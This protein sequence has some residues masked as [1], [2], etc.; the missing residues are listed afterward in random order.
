MLLTF[1]LLAP[2]KGIENVIQALP[3]V[4]ERHPDVVYLVLGATHLQLRAREG[5]SYRLAM[6]RLAR[7]LGVERQVIFH[8]RFVTIEELIEYI[9]SVDLYIT[10]YLKPMQIVSGTLAYTVGAGKA[11][12]STPYWYAREMLAEGRGILVLFR[13]PAAIA[14]Q[15]NHLLEHET[16]RHA[17]RKNAYQ[18]GR[19][20]IW[21]LVARRYL[22]SF[23]RAKIEHTAKPAHLVRVALTERKPPGLPSPRLNHLMRMTDG[24]GIFQYAIYTVPNY[25]E[26]Y[27]TDDNAR[28]LMLAVLLD[29]LLEEVEFDGDSLVS[30]YLAFLF[31]AHNPETRRFRNFMGFDRRWLEEVGSEDSHGRA[32]VGLGMMIGRSQNDGY[33]SLACQLFES[34]VGMV[35]DFSSPRAWAF[36]LIAI[37][38][39]LRAFSGDRG[40]CQT[41]AVLADRLLGMY[42]VNSAPDWRWFEDTLTYANALLPHA[43]ILSGQW[44]GRG[45]MAAT[46]LEALDWMTGIQT[47]ERRYFA[48][49]GSN[50]FYP[51]GGALARFDQ[52][53]IDAHATIAACL[54]AW[55]MTRDTAWKDRARQAFD[56][57]IGLNDLGVAVYDPATGGC[58]DGLHPDRVNRNQGAESTLAFL[59]SLAEMRLAE[60]IIGRNDEVPD[61]VEPGQPASKAI[62][63]ARTRRG[64]RA[65]TRAR[66]PGRRLAGGW[67]DCLYSRARRNTSSTLAQAAPGSSQASSVPIWPFHAHT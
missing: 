18:F 25:A 30:R 36:T 63:A 34:A 57:F 16:E 49:I 59:L 3:A 46:G 64:L 19:Q 39:Y 13:N 4:L 65:G 53:P 33:R 37:H 48:P 43:L 27:T 21:P 20:M 17:K 28:A 62:G 8:N 66:E 26:G 52:Q 29:E 55:R 10:P 11:I 61:R 5:E 15:V 42:R 35:E 45:D 67:K 40:V 41:R 38:E 7:S 24:I 47:S 2:D 44:T 54:E 32:L 58:H 51:R 31:N 9:G 22:E 23:A 6:Q 1:G 56:W 50:G 12:V 14:R 60:D